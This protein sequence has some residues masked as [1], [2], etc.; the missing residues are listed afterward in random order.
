[1]T[2]IKVKTSKQLYDAVKSSTA[3][4]VIEL[5]A[6][7]YFKDSQIALNIDH[8]LTIT[9]H[10]INAKS[11]INAAFIIGQATTLI[12]K[13]LS[14]DFSDD[15]LTTVAL[16][17]NSQLYCNNVIIAANNNG[18]FD[19]IY[20]RD[21]AISLVNSVILTNEYNAVGLSLENSQMTAVNSNFNTLGFKN[22]T[23]YLKDC[24]V[25]E[26]VGVLNKS[27]LSFS[28]L[29]IDSRSTKNLSDLYVENG[30]KLQGNDLDLFAPNPS[31]SV[32]NSSFDNIHFLSNIDNID[33]F[34]DDDSEV[35]ADGQEP[36]N[37][38]I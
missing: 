31:I 4:D 7:S 22:S 3:N 5:T 8:N 1:M 15:G 27:N 30:S 9:G 34:Y 23:G 18:K 2:L 13:N 14:V 35:S 33:W 24:L 32:T 19:T 11:I 37:S 28:G 16:Y 21:S 12:L 17:D 6:K 38:N 20:C 25:N 10:S 36:R 29:A 26:Y